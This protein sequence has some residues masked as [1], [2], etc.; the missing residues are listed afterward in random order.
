MDVRMWDGVDSR[1]MDSSS[2]T[3]DILD[4]ED[5]ELSAVTIGI[6]LGFP[7]SVYPSS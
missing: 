4:D 2:S 6:S 3:T 1:S 7:I 5:T